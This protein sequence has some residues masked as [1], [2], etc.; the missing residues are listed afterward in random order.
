MRKLTETDVVFKLRAEFD[1]LPVRG[2]AMASGDD[3]FDREVEDGVLA[4]LDA[5]DVWA[6]ASVEVTAEWEGVTGRDY[7]GACS[8]ASE[9]DFCAS[10]GY[11]EDMKAGALADLNAQVERM[12]HLVESLA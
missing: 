8:Y 1:D 6:W 9:D 4:R 12:T 2:N 5:G 11:F 10:G 3:A 7:L